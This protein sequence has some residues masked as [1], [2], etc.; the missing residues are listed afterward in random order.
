MRKILASLI[1]VLL[2]CM[3]SGFN[4]DAKAAENEAEYDMTQGGTQQFT[5]L[6]EDLEEIIITVEE[7]PTLSRAMKN[8][9]YKITSEKE[10]SW[11]A[12][13]EIVVKSNNITTVKNPSATAITG[14][15]TSKRLA[16]DSSTQATYYLTKKQEILVTDIHVRSKISGDKIVISN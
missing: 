8:G 2:L 4:M 14:S 1:G 6:D 13:Y 7:E 15:F 5:I 9:T 16:I 12:S 11:R 10:G 3:I